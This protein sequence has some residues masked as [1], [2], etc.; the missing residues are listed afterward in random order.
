M[1]TKADSKRRVVLPGAR[2]GDV[3]EVQKQGEGRFI[4]IR[5]ERPEPKAALSR[6]ECLRAMAAAPLRLKM[7]WDELKS[8]TRE[9]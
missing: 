8:M 4:L 6:E 3:Y 9:L 7:S 1:T 2:P 5:L